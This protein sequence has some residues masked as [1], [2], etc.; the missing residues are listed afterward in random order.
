M[1]QL[2]AALA[3][4]ADRCLRLVGGDVA[5]LLQRIAATDVHDLADGG[6]RRALFCDDKGRLVD[7]PLLWREA[8]AH[9]LLASEG[10]GEA[11]AHWIERWVIVEDVRIEWP[12]APLWLR[13][14]PTLREET[15]LRHQPADLHELTSE[16]L[17]AA[18]LRAGVFRPRAPLDFALHPLELGLREYVSFRKGC[19]IGQEVIARMENYEKV[20][21]GLAWL[22]GPAPAPAPGTALRAGNEVGHVLDTLREPDGSCLALVQAPLSFSQGAQIAGGSLDWVPT[23]PL[24]PA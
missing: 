18:W 7:L 12:A 15:L 3:C 22:R 17:A 1:I 8:Q 5:D 4:P 6:S 24:N 13:V 20:R 16:E 9:W 14:G 23:T 10:R 19:F 21:R 11:L 2:P